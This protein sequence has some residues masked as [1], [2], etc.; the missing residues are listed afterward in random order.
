[1]TVPEEVMDQW[2][3][4]LAQVVAQVVVQVVAQVVAMGQA[5]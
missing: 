5:R 1:V 2:Q 3:T 4:D